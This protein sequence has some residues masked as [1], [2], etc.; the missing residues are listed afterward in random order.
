MGFFD[1]FR[2]SKASGSDVPGARVGV[3]GNP[4]PPGE[5][6]PSYFAGELS[7]VQWV[8]QGQAVNA[9]RAGLD[10]HLWPGFAME[11][12]H[13]SASLHEHE[14][15]RARLG[16]QVKAAVRDVT[17]QLWRGAGQIA[18]ELETLH[19]VDQELVTA[20]KNWRRNYSKLEHNPTEVGRYQ[21]YSNT[22]NR[23]AKL[24]IGAAL[25]I[26]EWAMTGTALTSI[27]PGNL[28][29]EG[30]LVAIGITA[31]FVFVP[32]YAAIGI[33]EGLTRYHQWDLEEATAQ[34]RR[35]VSNPAA[36]V[37]DQGPLKEDPS[38]PG[39]TDPTKRTVPPGAEKVRLN[40][41]EKAED[42]VY[43]WVAALVGL[44][45]LAL[46]IPLSVVRADDVIVES[47]SGEGASLW[48]WFS[49]FLFLQLAVSGYFFLREWHDYG[50]LAHNL[51]YLSEKREEL[52]NHRLQVWSNLATANAEFLATAEYLHFNIRAAID[53]D[54][55]IV[56]HYNATV[57]HGRTAMQVERPDLHPFLT[58]ARLPLYVHANQIV[59]DTP[60][61]SSTW[62]DPAFE[63]ERPF[64]RRWWLETAN[65][66]LSAVD[67]RVPIDGDKPASDPNDGSARGGDGEQGEASES[68]G[69]ADPVDGSWLLTSTPP[70]LL[71][72]FM[73]LY[74]D[75]D[76]RYSR[77]KL[78]DEPVPDDLA[79][80][81]T[82]MGDD[83]QFNLGGSAGARTTNG[84]RVNGSGSS[85]GEDSSVA[86]TDV[87]SNQ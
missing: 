48:L 66:A 19:A 67:L 36:S 55:E 14:Q 50:T 82:E 74:F 51:H 2:R 1:R 20:T 27:I 21:R 23:I 54:R 18:T 25:I 56:A 81:V 28:G 53:W 64:G 7:T 44:L 30:Y 65:E 86:K 31:L 61:Q 84:S 76:V 43:L 33:K 38:G 3:E 79:G 9:A 57:D 40:E 78:F 70:Q 22:N 60:G 77:P 24:M 72:Y 8:T 46:V 12:S 71:E 4:A 13:E 15:I 26:T 16:A 52:V 6:G 10:P 32:H 5:G 34:P 58:L 37:A 62:R 85:G 45:L 87:D 41:T 35:G 68:P 73:D 42:R 63:E 83:P 80:V 11:F 69:R 49:L 75:L 29:F 59:E 17:G 47:A 39:T